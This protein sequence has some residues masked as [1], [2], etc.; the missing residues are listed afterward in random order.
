MVK[1]SQKT[2]KAFSLA[3]ILISLAIVGLVGAM[4]IVGITKATPNRNK[5]MF[6]K[7]YHALESAVSETIN[8]PTKY[9]QEL[10]SGSAQANYDF[11][12]AP[13]RTADSALCGTN[14]SQD[15]AVCCFV[16]DHFNIVGSLSC[17]DDVAK[18]FQASNG[19]CYGYM[20][21]PGEMTIDPLCDG[22]RIVVDIHEDGRMSVPSTHNASFSGSTAKLQEMAAK[23]M[24]E[25]TKLGDDMIIEEE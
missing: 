14:V 15:K 11:S 20:G 23:W 3:E 25:Q 10:Y 4:M 21:G 16:A 18:N 24:T 22:H 1:N 17:G 8:D 13:F 9:N 19:V 5:V 6:L 7:A 2:H 12:D